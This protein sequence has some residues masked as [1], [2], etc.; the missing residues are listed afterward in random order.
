M[1]G[2]AVTRLVFFWNYLRLL[3]RVRPAAIYSNTILNAGEVVIGR[4]LGSI[5]LVHIH[6]GETMMKRHAL[7]L[8]VS[9][10]FTTYYTC[11]SR[12]SARSLSSLLGRSATVIP[13]GTDAV[14]VLCRES[15]REA[16][17]P[18]L[19][20]I[21][22]IQPNKGHHVAIQAAAEL[23]QR[24]GSDLYL[25][26]YGEVDDP[27]YHAALI[28]LAREVGMDS[29]IEYRG[30]V[31]DRRAIYA[32]IDILLVPSFDECFP[33]VILEAFAHRRPVIA[34]NVGGIPEMIT[35]GENGLLVAPGDAAALG[36]AIDRLLRDAEL[37][38]KLV[39]AAST[40]VT[41]NFRLVD[42]TDKTIAFIE[43]T[44]AT[45]PGTHAVGE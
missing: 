9:S 1:V 37:A 29:C 27:A 11:V 24:T 28:T 40:E 6:E 26:F 12:Y 25:L 38:E 22:G 10:W 21:G 7:S 44:L 19:G 39:N 42:T 18:V 36:H 31:A 17:G 41:A 45:A 43:R 30:S 20:I 4:L 14:G 8:R 35:D 3:L 23:R 34:S 16:R 5:T 33:R 32:D 2:K 13:N 15:H